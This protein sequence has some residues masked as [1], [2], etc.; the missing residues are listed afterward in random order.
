M[1]L[2]SCFLHAMLAWKLIGEARHQQQNS[3]LLYLLILLSPLSNLSPDTRFAHPIQLACVVLARQ[4]MLS[5][6]SKGQMVLNAQSV[7]APGT[8]Q[9][10]AARQHESDTR[11]AAAAEAVAPEAVSEADAVNKAVLAGSVSS[12][13]RPG[14]ESTQPEVAGAT[15]SLPSDAAADHARHA[16][17]ALKDMHV[18]ADAQEPV[19]E[20]RSQPTAIGAIRQYA[21]GR[22]QAAISSMRQVFVGSNSKSEQASEQKQGSEKSND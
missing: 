9:T 3:C 8:H 16:G 1:S 22:V 15:G 4:F 14:I 13:A 2:T 17:S 20:V 10:T 6:G 11:Q 7:E 18:T 21:K 5:A 19:L 12:H